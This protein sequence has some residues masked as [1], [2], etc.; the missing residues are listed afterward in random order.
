MDAPPETTVPLYEFTSEDGATR[1]YA[2][3]DDAAIDGH[4]RADK[5]LCRVWRNPMRWAF[6][7]DGE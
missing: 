5:P 1:A 7:I 2:A 4:V 3:G 6:P